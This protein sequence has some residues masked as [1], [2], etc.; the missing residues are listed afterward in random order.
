MQF[1]VYFAIVGL[2]SIC[3][4]LT[5]FVGYLYWLQRKTSG[6]LLNLASAVQALLSNN[7]HQPPEEVVGLDTIKETPE[8]VSKQDDDDDKVSV[9]EQDEGDDTTTLYDDDDEVDEA[10]AGINNT[11]TVSEIKQLLTEKGIPFGKRDTKKVL[12]ELLNSVSA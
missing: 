12:L 10:T 8:L 9:I 11:R 7:H 2:S 1:I 6:Q 4:V 3:V 5:G